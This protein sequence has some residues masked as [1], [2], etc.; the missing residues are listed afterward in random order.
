M[1]QRFAAALKNIDLGE[2]DDGEEDDPFT[3]AQEKANEILTG[4]SEEERT[5]GELGFGVEEE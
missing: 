1:R 4:K 2:L 3:V 5:V